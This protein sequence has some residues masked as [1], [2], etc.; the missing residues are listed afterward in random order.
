MKAILKKFQKAT[1][2][3]FTLAE[4]LVVIFIISLLMLLFV[5]NIT[6][7]KDAVEQKN[8]EAVVKVVESQAQI[9]ELNNT[10]KASISKMIGKEITQKQADTYNDYAEKHP[11][12]MGTRIPA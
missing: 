12:K 11:D 4:M 7:Q 2:K 8:A 5:P 10:D 1:V 3:A 9:Y 6:K